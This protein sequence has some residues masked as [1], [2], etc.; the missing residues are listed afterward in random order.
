MSDSNVE[1]WKKKISQY[2]N[3]EWANKPS[4]FAEECLRYLPH[5]G[6]I[7]E[8]G[9]GYGNDGRWF[10]VQGYDVTQLDIED[11]RTDESKSLKFLKHDLNEPLDLSV[12]YDIVYAHLSLH[13]F[14]QKRT[15]A[16]MKEIHKLLTDD[17]ILA[18]LVNTTA[19]PECGEGEKIEENLYRINGIEKRYFDL[20]F[21]EILT[22][23]FFK[24][25]LL[26]DNGTSYKDRKSGLVHLVRYVGQKK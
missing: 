10:S 20:E 6:K 16:I 26:D 25:L 24:T 13:Y 8:V 12:K 11:Y 5:K 22:N 21:T 17:G 7:L 15:K 1:Y 3:E 14:T 9:A 23:E 18:F 19:D 4:L 2:S